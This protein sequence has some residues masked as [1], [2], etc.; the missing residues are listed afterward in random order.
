MQPLQAKKGTCACELCMCDQHVWISTFC[1]PCSHNQKVQTNVD[2]QNCLS[3]CFV[4]NRI[5][6]YLC[7]QVRCQHNC[8]ETYS[9]HNFLNL[10]EIL[11]I[12]APFYKAKVWPRKSQIAYERGGSHLLQSRGMKISLTT[13]KWS[14]IDSNKNCDC[15]MIWAL[16]PLMLPCTERSLP[17]GNYPT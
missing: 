12:Q 9:T 6:P 1:C 7:S 13:L 8:K 14:C 4:H 15:K 5:S 3:R 2:R 17:I 16:I 10:I 11:I